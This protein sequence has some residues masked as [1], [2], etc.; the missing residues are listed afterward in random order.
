MPPK[1]GQTD[2][3]DSR[4]LDRGRTFSEK[5]QIINIIGSVVVRSL[6]QLLSSAIVA[7][8]QPQ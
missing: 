4:D 5:S 1:L 8:V 6:V 7:P 3:P 2:R